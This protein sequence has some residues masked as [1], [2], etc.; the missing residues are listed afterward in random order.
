MFS[1]AAKCSL[2]GEHTKHR[3]GCVI[4][5]GGA[6]LSTGHN[7]LRYTK[8]L[9][10]PTLH[11]EADAILKV[12]KGQNQHL[13]VGAVM[14]VSRYTRGGNIGLAMPCSNC[15]ALIRSVGIKTVFYTTDE[16]TTEKMKV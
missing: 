12:L 16:G 11:A 7:Q 5:K 14:Y 1:L 15:L 8:Q 10:K 13:L 3:L 2:S 4:V 9:K 6:V